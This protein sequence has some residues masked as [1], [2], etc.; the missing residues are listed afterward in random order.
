[1]IGN[2]FTPFRIDETKNSLSTDLDFFSNGGE[3]REFLL[4]R[5]RLLQFY[6]FQLSQFEFVT[7]GFFDR[8]FTVVCFR[9]FSCLS[10]QLRS[11]VVPTSLYDVFPVL[12]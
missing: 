11:D 6:I 4:L 10:R 7:W 2:F 9:I 5:A 1:M 12:L 8:S 3:P